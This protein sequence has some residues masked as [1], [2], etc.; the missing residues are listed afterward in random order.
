MDPNEL[1]KILLQKLERVIEQKGLSILENLAFD[2][3]ILADRQ[4]LS[5]ALSNVLEN[6]VKFTPEKGSVTV[7]TRSEDG[8]LVIDVENTCEPLSTGAL[9]KIF[10]P[11][12]RAKREN[13]MGTGLGLAIAKKIIQKHGGRIEATNAEAG[14]SIRMRIPLEYSPV[15]A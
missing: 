12:Y 13:A 5:T 3:T 8:L 11:F 10:E 15:N 7:M 6:A 1:I 2:R 4:T 14:M 9:S